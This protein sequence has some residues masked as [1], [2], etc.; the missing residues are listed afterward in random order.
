[1]PVRRIVPKDPSVQAAQRLAMTTLLGRV[2]ETVDLSALRT[3]PIV[4]DALAAQIEQ[5][6]NEA[7]K[8]MRDEGKEG[9]A[10]DVDLESIGH[11]A[12][13]ELVGLGALEPLLSDEEVVEIHCVRFGQVF[14]MRGSPVATE[15]TEEFGFSSEEALERVIARLVH[16]SGESLRLGE[17][18]VERRL[19]RASF[20]AISPPFASNHVLTVRKLRRAETT[21][22]ELVHKNSLSRPMAQFLEACVDARANILVAGASCTSTAL[23][24]LAAAGAPG[25][26]VVVVHDGEEIGVG[27]AQVVNLPSDTAPA[28]GE[29]AV[30]AAAALG[31][32][33][34]LVGR[35][36]GSVAAATLDAITRGE[37]NVFAAVPATSLRQGVARVV[38]QLVL[39]RHG[40]AIDAIR[41][42]VGEAFDIAIEVA[43]FADGRMRMI[44]IAE[45]TYDGPKGLIL[46]DLFVF[47]PDASG[48]DGTFAPSGVVPRIATDFAS[49]GVRLDASLFKRTSR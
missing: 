6:A 23:A 17:S 32:D 7:A 24:A 49:R 25:E 37:A 34:L 47:T 11:N 5:A 3:S 27:S 39:Y 21:L 1:M 8:A 41:E 14:A 42:M 29:E 44:R 40:V 22:D 19:D 10:H 31:P 16:Q 12:H 20:V 13:R 18:V 38:A 26:H 33:R 36:T 15:V 4:S 30:H 46:R 43:P 35:L 28:G 48:V 9:K 45:L 2:A